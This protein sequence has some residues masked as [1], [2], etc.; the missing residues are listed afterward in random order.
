MGAPTIRLQLG[1]A[2]GVYP[3]VARPKGK[4]ANCESAGDEAGKSRSSRADPRYSSH[5]A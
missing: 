2:I 5:S 4:G 3:V 1:A